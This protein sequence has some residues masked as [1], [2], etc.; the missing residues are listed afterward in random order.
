MADDIGAFDPGRAVLEV[1]PGFWQID[2][3]F[4][5]RGGVIAAY[6][7]AGEDYLVLIES[8]PSSCLAN[9]RAGIAR[10]GYALS[11]LTHALVTHIHLDHAGA[12]GPLARDNPSLQIRVHPFG[13]PHLIDPAKLVASATRIYGERMDKLWGEFCP[14]D[15]RQVVPL[16]NGEVLDLAGRRLTT[17]FTPGHAHH[18]VAYVDLAARHAFTGDVGGVRMQGT[19]YV[20]PPTPPPDLDPGLW[21]ESIQRLK[22]CGLERLYLTHFGE[23]LDAGRHLADLGP[24]L[25]E[26]LALGS[27]A[28]EAG[29]NGDEITAILHERMAR[30]LGDVPPGIVTNLEWATPSYMAT[31]GIQRW[32]RKRAEQNV[33][34][35]A[36]KPSDWSGE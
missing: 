8:G 2:L 23:F 32:H 33:G 7:L 6:L 15:A 34:Q 5:N 13:A 16:Q 3:G 11:D 35:D 30:G 19:D 20:C 9:L 4:Q 25:D 28:I 10:T 14:I 36:H 18:H 24:N 31:L 29:R 21:W 12:C 22:E 17:I 1:S 26:F 27:A